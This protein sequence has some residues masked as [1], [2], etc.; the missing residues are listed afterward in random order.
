MKISS[1]FLAVIFCSISYQYIY[2]PPGKASEGTVFVYK[3]DGTKQCDLSPPETLDSMEAE[4]T[5]IG[6]K[7]YSKKKG[8]DGRAGVALCG[9]PTGQINIYEITSSDS[10]TADDLGFKKFP[11]NRIR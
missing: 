7:V 10:S 3:S 5:S 8:Y 11:Q 9:S 6:I 1:I 4:L 2:C